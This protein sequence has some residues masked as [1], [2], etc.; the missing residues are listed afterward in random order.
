M[1]P[2][3]LSNGWYQIDGVNQ[4]GI[5]VQPGYSGGGVWDD[6]SGALMGMVVA[7]LKSD[8]RQVAWMISTELLQRVCPDLALIGALVQLYPDHVVDDRGQGD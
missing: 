8:S 6:E 3:R 5:Y 2:G 7:A 1:L 4:V